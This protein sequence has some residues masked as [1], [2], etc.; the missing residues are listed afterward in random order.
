MISPSV[1]TRVQLGVGQAPPRRLIHW[2][3]ITVPL[4]ELLAP[5]LTEPVPLKLHLENPQLS[6]S[7]TEIGVP[8]S[9]AVQ[10]TPNAFMTALP[11]S[12]PF[13]VQLPAESG[14]R[15]IGA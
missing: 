14:A 12:S 7:W 13:C 4:V 1:P 15:V 2:Y 3:L 6:C 10:V 8:E 11:P 9:W 5:E